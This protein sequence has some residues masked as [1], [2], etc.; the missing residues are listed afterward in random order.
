MSTEY[1][2]IQSL[3]KRHREGPNRGSFMV[4]EW[5]RPVLGYLAP[6]EWE[7]TEKVDGMNIR[8]GLTEG[9]RSHGPSAGMYTEE[10]MIVVQR[11]SRKYFLGGRTERANI[12]AGLVEHV[13]GLGLREKLPEVFTDGPVTLYGEG[14]GAGI[15]KGGG[16]R[17]DKAFVL[18]DVK[19]G[20]WW[21]ERSDVEDVA[22]KLGLDVVPV[23]GRGTLQEA[24]DF[25]AAGFTSRWGA[26]FEPEGLVCRPSVTVFARSGERVIV[27]IKGKD[28]RKAGLMP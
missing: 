12:P 26:G 3:F 9:F 2:K 13:H 6:C 18:F 19:V 21:L 1:H 20:D 27:K 5:A 14:Y 16:Y 7:W 17:H 10:E 23:V 22:Q 11:E 4:G 24:I 15:Q 8:I 25:V 28:L